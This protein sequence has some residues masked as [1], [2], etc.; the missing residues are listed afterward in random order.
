MNERTDNVLWELGLLARAADARS[1]GGGLS[2]HIE[3]VGTDTRSLPPQSLFVALR[4]ENFDGHAFVPDAVRAG[5]VAV[6]MD[7]TGAESLGDDI[8]SQ[9]PL[10]VVDDTLRAYGD[11]A[12]C[13]RRLM[14][15]PL[16]AVTGSNGKT[17]TKELIA[18]GLSPRG[19]VHK[20]AGNF[21]NLV[22]LPKTLLAWGAEAWTSVVELGMNV[23]GEI[24]RLTQIAAPTVGVITNVA[25]AHLEGLG[26]IEGV[27]RAKGELFASLPLNAVGIVNLDDP[28]VLGIC[29]PMLD[30]RPRLTFGRA[31][32]AD[33]RIRSCETT[34]RGSAITLAIESREITFEVPLY[35]AHNASNVAAAF[36]AGLALGSSPESL[37]EGMA[38]VSVPGGRARVLRAEGG[39][40]HVIDD[41]YNANPA[42]MRAAFNMLADLAGTGRRVAALGTMFELG[43]ASATLHHEVG[44]AAAAAGIELVLGAG[45]EA[46]AIRAGAEAGGAKAL[47]FEQV[48]ELISVVRGEL[49][50]GDWLLVKGSRGMRM[51]RVVQAVTETEEVS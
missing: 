37:A 15:R 20:T 47:A 48:D 51:E 31:A 13:H 22:G 46:E 23:P 44:Q 1:R 4:G 28:M 21:N 24:E 43:E 19:T 41:T 14:A 34:G 49:D 32:Q 2:S 17:T 7:E 36:T 9:V 50:D 25:G 6:M 11:M 12:G 3:A 16:V 40:C 27:A 38:E 5:C 26:S 35:G 39:G 42:S 33:V 30:G 18:A 45:P 10:L 8:S 29:A